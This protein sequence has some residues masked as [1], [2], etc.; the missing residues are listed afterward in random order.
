VH[1]RPVFE[2]ESERRG[3]QHAEVIGRPGRGG[4][5]GGDGCRGGGGVEEL[6]GG[7]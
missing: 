5:R 2:R 4:A 6:T 7:R 1:V 3:R